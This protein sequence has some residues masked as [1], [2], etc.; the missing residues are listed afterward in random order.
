MGFAHYRYKS[1]FLFGFRGIRFVVLGLIK[2]CFSDISWSLFEDLII[3]RLE[4]FFM[5][6]FSIHLIKISIWIINE[7]NLL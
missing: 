3:K 2:E 5:N 1:F 4:K 7:I 6:M